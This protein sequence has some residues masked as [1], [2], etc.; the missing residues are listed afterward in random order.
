MSQQKYE[1]DHSGIYDMVIRM[2]LTFDELISLAGMEYNRPKEELFALSSGNYEVADI[3]ET[4]K[5]IWPSTLVDIKLDDTTM[6]T[7]L[8]IQSTKN[9]ESKFV[10]KSSLITILGHMAI[11]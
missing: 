2:K 8:T 3:N 11:E 6:R 4:T 10:E 9:E 5:N 7:N 1:A